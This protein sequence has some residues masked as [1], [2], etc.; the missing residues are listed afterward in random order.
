[1]SRVKQNHATFHVLQKRVSKNKMACSF[2]SFTYDQ[3][4][5]MVTIGEIVIDY[6]VNYSEITYVHKK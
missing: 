4:Y 1:M 6:N 5:V 3:K 2:L